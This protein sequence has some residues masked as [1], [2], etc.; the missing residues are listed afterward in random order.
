MS[1]QSGKIGRHRFHGDPK[2][3]EVITDF[4]ISKY[5]KKIKY[6]ADVA[7][8]RGMLTRMLNKKNYE[9]EVVDPRGWALKG[10][11]TREEE[12]NSEMAD[13]YDL[14][15]GLHPDEA[16]RA[17]VESAKVSLTLIIPCCNF[18]DR[19]KTLGRDALIGEIE[20]YYIENNIAYEKITF[21]FKGPMNIGLS[22][23][24]Q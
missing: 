23:V 21:D 15:I 7:G 19:S 10:V 18:W 24:P 2:R 6:I 13:Y 16:T 22:T 11:P 5:G 12:F 17:V 4:V 8:G 14:I 3:F 1:T 9:A 20:N